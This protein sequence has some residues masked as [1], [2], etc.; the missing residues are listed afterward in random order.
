M[1][2]KMF[3]SVE[4]HNGGVFLYRVESDKEI[5]IEDVAA[6]LIKN[7]DWNEDKDSIDLI[8]DD[9]VETIKI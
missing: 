4:Y 5:N 2:H 8:A 9:A 7:C 3:A 6:W 1:K